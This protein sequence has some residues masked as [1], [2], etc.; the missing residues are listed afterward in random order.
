MEIRKVCKGVGHDGKSYFCWN[1]G[2]AGFVLEEQAIGHQA[3][4]PARKKRVELPILPTYLSTH[5]QPSYDLANLPIQLPSEMERQSSNIERQLQAIGRDMVEM[6]QQYAKIY[7]EVPHLQAVGQMGFL[8]ISTNVWLLFGIG[9]LIVYSLGK[10]S[11]C[12]CDTGS[13]RRRLGSTLQDKVADKAISY[14]LS[15]LFK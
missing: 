12:H 5:L 11:K 3:K 4:C 13:P 1:C 10:E 9:L 14:G 15:K 6:K 8:G 2:K 7:N